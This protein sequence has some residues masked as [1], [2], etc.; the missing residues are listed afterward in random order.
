LLVCPFNDV[1]A[2]FLEILQFLVLLIVK[3]IGVDVDGGLLSGSGL[4]DVVLLV[5]DVVFLFVYLVEG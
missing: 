2:D 3:E 5:Y 4:E 1:M